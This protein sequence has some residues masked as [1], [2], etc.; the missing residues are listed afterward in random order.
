MKTLP[1]STLTLKRSAPQPS[2]KPASVPAPSIE[3]FFFVW[4]PDAL[5]PKKRHA[6]AEAAQA[7]AA[8]LQAI[9]A[10]RQFLVYEAR[11]LKGAA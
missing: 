1:R 8:R 3:R 5:R 6:T 11:L 10:E 9:A 7:E 2:A 4:C